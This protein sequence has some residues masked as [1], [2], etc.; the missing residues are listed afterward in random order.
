M[1]S[2]LESLKGA[3]GSAGLFASEVKR[4]REDLERAKRRREDLMSLPPAKAD[5]VELLCGFIDRAADH[6][7][8]MLQQSIAGLLRQPLIAPEIAQQHTEGLVLTL[9]HSPAGR[10]DRPSLEGAEAALM[11]V[12]RD[13]FKKAIADAVNGMPWPQATGPRRRDREAELAKLA[14]EIPALEEKLREFAA[15]KAKIVRSF[16]D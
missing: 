1:S 3:L 2:L 5:V 14:V 11:Y 7:P 15:E 12:H 10:H 13:A 6:Y 8:A 4:V 9:R 16:G